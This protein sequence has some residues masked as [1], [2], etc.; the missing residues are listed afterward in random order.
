[1]SCS[2]R[3]PIGLVLFSTLCYCTL[4]NEAKHNKLLSA[5]GL[6][7]MLTNPLLNGGIAND[8]MNSLNQ[9]NRR[10]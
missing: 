3:N 8:E 9:P 4:E 6:K 5:V 2:V 1:M 7:F 10:P